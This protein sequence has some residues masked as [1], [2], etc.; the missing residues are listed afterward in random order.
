[1]IPSR[2]LIML[3]L[4]GAPWVARAQDAV[5]CE[6][7]YNIAVGLYADDR[8][9][10]GL[11]LLDS[12]TLTCTQDR[13]QMARVLF[14]K[15][16]I[17]ARNDSVKAMR[18]SMERLFRNDRRYVLS[19]YDP[20]IVKIPQKE[21]I[22]DTYEGLIGARGK[23][24]G[25]LR[26]DH[27]Q[28]RAGFHAGIQRS[29]L[30]LG[31]EE[32]VFEDDPLPAYESRYGWQAGADMRWDLIPNL[33]VRASA[34]WSVMDYEAT[35][36]VINYRE[37]VSLVPISLGLEKKFWI[38]E[39]AWVPHVFLEGTWSGVISCDVDIAR[40]GDGLR[41]LPPKSLDRSA[42]RRSS[43]ASID[44]GIGVGRKL[45]HTVLVL[46]ARYQHAFRSLTLEDVRY[47]ETELLTN[48]YWLDRSVTLHALSV[49]LGVQ[50]VLKYHRQNRIFR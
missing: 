43:Q 1:M 8:L 39:Q 21:R 12:L 15:A 19:P 26:K 36:S 3:L 40:S 48:Y 20:L 31:P 7:A 4:A 25:L 17:E 2:G 34:G 42:E 41:Y 47:T 11:H 18:S 27:G 38:G 33:A 16:V 28:W 23:G 44:G 22:F 50:Y 10:E 6:E 9:V 5:S 30:D 46:E 45:G 37:R 14:L 49:T 24:P 29:V 35:S 13:G 32:K